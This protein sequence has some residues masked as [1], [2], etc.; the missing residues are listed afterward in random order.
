MEQKK[1]IYGHG[2]LQSHLKI[3]TCV[4]HAIQRD[5]SWNII[6]FFLFVFD[7]FKQFVAFQNYF[8]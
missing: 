5:A 1:K 2:F 3:S 4:T 6:D 8:K 7:I